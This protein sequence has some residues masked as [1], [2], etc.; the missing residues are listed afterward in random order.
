[1]IKLPCHPESTISDPLS[2]LD[3]EEVLVPYWDFLKAL[4]N[5]FVDETGALEEPNARL[6]QFIDVLETISYSVTGNGSP[7][8]SLLLESASPTQLSRLVGPI[9]RSALNMKEL[10]PDGVL[11]TFEDPAVSPKSRSC[12]ENRYISS[13]G[14]FTTITLDHAQLSCLL[15]HMIL[16]TFSKPQWM[17]W[18]GPCLGPL[19][20]A[21][22]GKG[23]RRIKTAYIHVLLAFLEE[24]LI[25]LPTTLRNQNGRDLKAVR[26]SLFDLYGRSGRGE[27]VQ[28]LFQ[29]EDTE[30][31]LK[32]LTPLNVYFL[33]EEDDDHEPCFTSSPEDNEEI[34]QL[35][36]AN[37][38]IG[39]G[40]TGESTQY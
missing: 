9:V 20:F 34:C 10:F 4:L 25:S 38:E 1:M 31:S 3:S 30:S 18:N 36:S 7:N 22:D 6:S 12:T 23:D 19:W 5:P 21:D 35:V 37:K 2:I 13:K 8:F 26:F 40:P 32:S 17:S 16:G 24:E 15:C 29:L 39:F 11:P 28:P 33:E 27:S 14:A